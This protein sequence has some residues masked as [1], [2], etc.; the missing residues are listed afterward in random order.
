MIRLDAAVCRDQEQASRREWWLANGIGG[1]AGG[2]VS[3]ILARRYHGLLIAPVYPPLGRWLLFAKADAVLLDADREF[4][5]HSNRWGGGVVAPAAFR[6][7]EGFE[8]RDGLPLWRYALN[9]LIIEQ[10]LWMP[11]GE[12][13]TLLAWR[14]HKGE[15]TETPRLRLG[16][17]ASCRDHHGVSRPGGFQL[18]REL[19]P[20]GLRLHLP[21]GH[22]LELRAPQ[23]RF[24]LDDTWIENFHLSLEQKRGLEDIDAHLRIGFLEL[25][26]Q[27][28]AWTGIDIGLDTAAAVDFAESLSAETGRRSRLRSQA[29]PGLSPGDTPDWI[30]ELA[31]AADA[32]LFRRQGVDGGAKASLIAG[33]PWFGDWGRDTMIALPGLTLATGRAEI[34]REILQTFAGYVSQGMLPNVFPGSGDT[35]EY[36]TVD[37][38]LWFIEA[39]RAYFQMSGDR[40]SLAA[41]YPRLLEII[42][43]YR[44][45]TRYGIAMDA[46]DGLIRAGVPGQQ[47]T[48]MDARVDGRE[49]TPRHGKPVEINALWYNALH[50]MRML[51]QAIGKPAEEF[52]HLAEQTER[53]FQR[54]HRGGGAGLY[55]VLD[56][57][58]GHEAAI[59]PNQIFALSLPHSPLHDDSLRRAVL[60]ECR[61]HL[62]TPCGLRSLS[63]ADSRYVGRYLG[64]VRARDGSYHQGPV[65]GWLLGHFALAEYRVLG[66]PAAAQARLQPMAGQLS[67][68]GLGQISEIFDGDPPHAPRGTPAQAWSVACTLEAWWRLERAKS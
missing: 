25:P 10:R 41:V 3:G 31:V 27:R 2:T 12:N 55:D 36:N 64:G 68:A 30:G 5:L 39:W 49:I 50:A 57:P 38:A 24:E 23:G 67:D 21:Q 47:L 13:R 59:R 63:P 18:H 9:D 42:H 53:G 51:A 48:W 62:L 43:A 44:E 20:H 37:A 35:P 14:L 22:R 34:A 32:Y 33:Y 60:T 17:I 46:H 19:M 26:L 6:T 1:Y 58:Q 65:W 66:D 16:L 4:P 11:H 28:D 29:L 61:D 7:L 8:L 56:G 54:F 52:L 45:G 15:R 40:D